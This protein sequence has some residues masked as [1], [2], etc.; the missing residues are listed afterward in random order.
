MARVLGFGFSDK[1]PDPIA[2]QSSRAPVRGRE[3]NPEFA[4]EQGMQTKKEVVWLTS[5]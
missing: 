3:S 4:T 1:N 5:P 2:V